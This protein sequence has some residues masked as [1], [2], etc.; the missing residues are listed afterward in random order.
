[1]ERMDVRYIKMVSYRTCIP[2]HKYAGLGFNA[3]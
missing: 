1:M 2:K 3:A